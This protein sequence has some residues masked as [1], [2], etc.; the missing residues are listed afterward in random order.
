MIRHRVRLTAIWGCSDG[1][2]GSRRRREVL[3][4]RGKGAG[5]GRD[6]PRAVPVSGPPPAPSREGPQGPLGVMQVRRSRT[7]STVCPALIA[8]RSWRRLRPAPGEFTSDPVTLPSAGAGARG[9]I[10][11]ARSHR[12]GVRPAG[13]QARSD[14]VHN[15]NDVRHCSQEQ[16]RDFLTVSDDRP[17]ERALNGRKSGTDG[18]TRSRQLDRGRSE[19]FA[20]SGRKLRAQPAARGGA[21]W[22]PGGIRGRP[23][24]HAGGP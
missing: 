21:V 15:S 18:S 1:G 20:A 8:A 13:R 6:A 16:S 10:R 2:E 4:D 19:M 5:A 7:R 22:D 24:V 11:S 12:Q 14:V 17:L 3:S 23:G 9:R